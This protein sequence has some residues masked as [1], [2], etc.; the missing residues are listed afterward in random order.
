MGAMGGLSALARVAEPE[1]RDG[2]PGAKRG[3][4]VPGA[5][6]SVPRFLYELNMPRDTHENALP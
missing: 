2:V 6:R 1:S 3:G 5:K 4:R